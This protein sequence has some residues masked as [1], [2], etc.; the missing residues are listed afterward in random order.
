MP[1]SARPSKGW[2]TTRRHSGDARGPEL[3]V[4]LR[5]DQ[6]HLGPHGVADP[7]L[8]AR[9]PPAAF[10]AAR[11]HA[12]GGEVAARAVFRHGGAADQLAAQHGGHVA[13]ARLG[14]AALGDAQDGVVVVDEGEGE[15]EVHARQRLGRRRA[16]GVGQAV[17][18]QGLRD[19]DARQAP[20][21]G[22]ADG[23]AGP[24]LC[25]CDRRDLGLRE[26]AQ[27]SQQRRGLGRER[28][29]A[30]AVA[31]CA[32]SAMAPCPASAAIR[33]GE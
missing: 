6:R 12:D 24:L 5:E 29:G 15:R 25:G 11:G 27:F 9:E 4:G 33:S 19:L 31:S 23:R 28:V 14:A 18:A 26:G 20:R 16:H 22:R 2:S 21:A 32:G 30:H 3:R 8:A 13:F 10:H 7:L 1:A 17:A